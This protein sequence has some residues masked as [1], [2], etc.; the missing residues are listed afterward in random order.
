[1]REWDLGGLGLAGV[2]DY[3]H[4]PYEDNQL[5]FQLKG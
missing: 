5:T 4:I 1:M 2:L 3:L